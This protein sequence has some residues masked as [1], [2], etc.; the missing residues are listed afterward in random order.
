MGLRG[1]PQLAVVVG[2]APLAVAHGPVAV[3]AAA[4]RREASDNCSSDVGAAVLVNK[5]GFVRPQVIGKWNR[6][7]G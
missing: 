7:Q 2:V 1:R 3:A 4:A 6:K 5:K